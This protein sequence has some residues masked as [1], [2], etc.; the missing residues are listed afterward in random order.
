MPK[1]LPR[2]LCA[3][4]VTLAP[5]LAAAAAV[6][7]VFEGRIPC[8]VQSGVQFCEGGL[9]TRVE[10]F[11]G[12]PLDVNVTLPPAS[13]D[14]PFPLIVDLHGWSLLKSGAPYVAWAEA[15]YAVLS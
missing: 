3:L 15:G 1:R 8:A 6:P 7:S 2:A 14:G 4:A 5:S 13:M 11:D 12:V 10:T 9:S